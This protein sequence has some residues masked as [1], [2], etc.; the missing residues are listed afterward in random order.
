MSSRLSFHFKLR[1]RPL[2]CSISSAAPN[3][4]DL[5]VPRRTLSHPPLTIPRPFSTGRIASLVILR[6]GSHLSSRHPH[7]VPSQR[8]LF[9]ASGTAHP[10]IRPLSV[11]LAQLFRDLRERLREVL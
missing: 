5:F 10:G 2:I 4:T 1:S 9:R 8:P 6:P 3:V 7:P 11:F